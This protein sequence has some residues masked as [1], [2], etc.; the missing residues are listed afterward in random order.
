MTALPDVMADIER[1]GKTA[2]RIK[3]ERDLLAAVLKLYVKAYHEEPVGDSDL[4]DEQPR[5]IK[6]TLGLYRLAKQTLAQCGE[7]L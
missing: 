6:I 3:N 5:H 1:L 2:L 7:P 4:D